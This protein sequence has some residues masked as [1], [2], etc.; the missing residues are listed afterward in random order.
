VHGEGINLGGMK[1]SG[2]FTRSGAGAKA[3]ALI[4]TYAAL[5]RRS[6]TKSLFYQVLLLLRAFFLRAFFAKNFFANSFFAQEL[7]LPTASLLRA[8][9][10]TY[11]NDLEG[12]EF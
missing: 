4:G 12:E 10:R 1:L 7:L 6:S 9:G 8:K 5:K 11:Q 2:P 3:Q